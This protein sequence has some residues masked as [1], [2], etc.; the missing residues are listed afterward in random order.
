M[1]PSRVL[2]Q[3]WHGM[4]EVNGPRLVRSY[5]VFDGAVQHD[6]GRLDWADYHHDGSLLFAR[7]GRLY[8]TKSNDTEREVPDLRSLRFRA[9][10]SRPEARQWPPQK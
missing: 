2:Q 8:R 7:E 10:V 1:H 5:A 6:L 9:I 4:F 3:N